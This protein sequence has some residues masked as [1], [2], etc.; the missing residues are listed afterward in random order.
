MI[1]SNA[2][3]PI[4]TNTLP[5]HLLLPAWRGARGSG[6]QQSVAEESLPP[7]GGKYTK[8][9]TGLVTW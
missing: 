3:R 4:A 2:T 8:T 5:E 9:K 6:G 1:F 7:P